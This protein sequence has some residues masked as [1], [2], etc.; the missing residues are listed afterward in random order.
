MDFFFSN[1]NVLATKIFLIVVYYFCCMYASI[2][3]KLI[4]FH[5]RSIICHLDAKVIS[6]LSRFIKIKEE[7]GEFIVDC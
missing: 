6:E 7:K 5:S 4:I 3:L 1:V 2:I